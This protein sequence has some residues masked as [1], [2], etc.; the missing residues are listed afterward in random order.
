M[1]LIPRLARLM[2]RAVFVVALVA[3]FA[4]AV[5][6][7]DQTPGGYNDKVAHLCAFYGLA[8]LGLAGFQQRRTLAWLAGGLIVYGCAIEIVQ[9][10]T[11]FG[12][13]ADMVDLIAD[14]V[15]IMAVIAPALLAG[16]RR[17]PADP[18]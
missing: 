11:P 5:L 1:I 12:R 3:I 13:S 16:W 7:Q 14:A 2:V 8:L 18:S 15:G 9:G 17:N 6:P 4:I 10:V